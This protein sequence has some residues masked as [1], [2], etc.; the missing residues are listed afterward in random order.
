M[1]GRC[2]REGTDFGVVLIVEGQESGAVA[3]MADVGTGARVVDS[4]ACPTGCSG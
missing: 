3:A 4:A 2:M 1:V